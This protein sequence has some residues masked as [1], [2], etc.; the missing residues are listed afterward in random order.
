M[1]TEIDHT[2]AQVRV[3]GVVSVVDVIE[4]EEHLRQGRASA[5]IE[6]CY[7]PWT[8]DEFIVAYQIPALAEALD[9]PNARFSDHLRLGGRPIFS[10]LFTGIVLLLGLVQLYLSVRGWT[11]G[12]LGLTILTAFDASVTGF[13]Q[14]FLDGRWWSPW[15]SQFVHAG[16]MHLF[17]NLAVVGYTGYRVERALGASATAVV[18]ASSIFFGGLAVGMYSS[19][20]V[21][22]SSIAGYGLL[23]AVIVVGFRFGDT[24]PSHHQR[25]YGYGN[26]LLFALLFVSGLRIENA[27]MLGHFGGLFGG[28]LATAVVT[29]SVATSRRIADKVARKN[30]FVTALLIASPAFLTPV[31]S[32]VP[33]VLWGDR[34]EVESDGAL[35]HLPV[36]LESNPASLRGLRAWTTSRHSNEAMFADLELVPE[37]HSWEGDTQLSFWAGGGEAQFE[38]PPANFQ[39]GEA[40]SGASILRE[41]DLGDQYRVVEYTQQRGRWLYRFGYQVRVDKHGYSAPRGKLFAWA[42]EGIEIL[43][44]EA[45]QEARL[46]WMSSRSLSRGS[47]LGEQLGWWGDYEGAERVFSDSAELGGH[48]SMSSRRRYVQ[49]ARRRLRVWHSAPNIQ[50][51]DQWLIS[52]LRE[53][54]RDSTLNELGISWLVSQGRCGDALPAMEAHLASNDA[55]SVELRESLETNCVQ[56]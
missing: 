13:E 31:F 11:M 39:M 3:R 2:D 29:P 32:A 6:I 33:S 24:I 12:S 5:R 7:P 17:P 47:S 23:G 54:S 38:E 42:L 18:V 35:L 45:L 49:Y 51:D 41:D 36:R 44:P 20:P 10:S 16:P 55:A 25:F 19:L 1:T 26:V 46:A 53:Y 30:L 50:V 15:S 40:F 4:L 27:S 9:T 52:T 34:V 37:G 14:I 43:E 48:I 56:Q 21:M 22:G 8:G 28:I